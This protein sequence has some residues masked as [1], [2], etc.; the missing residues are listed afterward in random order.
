VTRLAETEDER[1]TRIAAIRERVGGMYTQHPWPGTRQTDEE[2]GWRLRVLG[3]RPED[4]TDRAVLEL[5][6]GT[7]EYA[8]WYAT[9]GAGTSP[10]WTSLMALSPARA[11][12]L[13]ATA[14]T[15]WTS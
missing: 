4:Y 15:T 7:G 1:A 6:C 2:M 10:A 9:H 8:L 5:G 3:V 11:A 13:A 12:R 14:S